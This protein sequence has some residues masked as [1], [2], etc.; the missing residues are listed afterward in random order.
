VYITQTGT[1]HKNQNADFNILNDGD[2]GTF[3]DTSSAQNIV[4]KPYESFITS[5]WF[6]W[7]TGATVNVLGTDYYSQETRSEY[8]HD[9]D[10]SYYEILTEDVRYVEYSFILSEPITVPVPEI[11]GNSYSTGLVTAYYHDGFGGITTSTTGEHYAAG[12]LIWQNVTN[13]FSISLPSGTTTDAS[14]TGDRYEWAGNGTSYYY[15]AW[16]TPY[17]TF[18][19]EYS[20]EN[21]YHDGN[22]G[23]YTVTI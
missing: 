12:T 14:F 18:I 17:G 7:D 22:G 23:Y 8:L 13:N 9:G 11:G 21:Y 15:S 20:G 16:N 6:L 3:I 10:G 19:E 2:C 5:Y 1:S 4:F